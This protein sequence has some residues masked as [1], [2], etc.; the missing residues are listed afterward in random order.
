MKRWALKFAVAINAAIIGAHAVAGQN[1][2]Q[3]YDTD[4]VSAF[5]SSSEVSMLVFG[6]RT[7]GPAGDAMGFDVVSDGGSAGRQRNLTTP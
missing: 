4:S 6:Q 7:Q 5:A 3:M 1:G 2:A